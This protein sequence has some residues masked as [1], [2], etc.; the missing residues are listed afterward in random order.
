VI[1]GSPI[2]AYLTRFD[3]PQRAA[4]ATTVETIR[5]AL[6]GAAEV[7]SYGMPT[8]RAGGDGGAAIVGLDGFRQHNSL[9]PYS[10]GVLQQFADEVDVHSKGTIH[11]DRD[12]AFPAGVLRRILRLRIQEINASYPKA[13]GQFRAYYPTGRLKAEG[14]MRGE[15]MTGAWRFYRLDGTPLRSG[16]FRDGERTGDWTTYDRAG[17][18]HRVTRF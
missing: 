11:F 2:D 7:I 17:L 6:P 10:G 12:R 18:P 9:F 15:L 4:L 3:D 1:A 14:R 8:F 16:S 5:R 13:S